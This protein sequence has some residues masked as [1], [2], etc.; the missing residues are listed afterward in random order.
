MTL[1]RA[2]PCFHELIP[3]AV[4]WGGIHPPLPLEANPNPTLAQTLHL[5]QGRLGASPGGVVTM[6]VMSS[7]SDG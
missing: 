7:T 6:I 5:T 3:A 2:Q 4:F 1:W